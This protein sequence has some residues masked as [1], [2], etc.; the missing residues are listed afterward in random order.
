VLNQEFPL[1][2]S[3]TLSQKM[4]LHSWKRDA[5][6]ER[7]L[8]DTLRF[9]LVRLSGI[10]NI[11]WAVLS[12]LNNL[13]SNP[14]AC[15]CQCDTTTGTNLCENEVHEECLPCATRIIQEDQSSY[16]TIN[17]HHHPVINNHLVICKLWLCLF[18]V[19]KMT[20]L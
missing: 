9:V 2:V 3:V 5:K 1:P 12:T 14:T 13:G 20:W 7:R 16:P 11:E 8:D 17:V 15:S 19:I 10:S 18:N 6:A 4:T